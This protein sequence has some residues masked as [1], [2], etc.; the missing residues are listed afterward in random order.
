MTISHDSAVQA[1]I[2]SSIDPH[3][4]HPAKPG[5]GTLVA[6]S[7]FV[8]GLLSRLN[9]E[10][11][12]AWMLANGILQESATRAV[13]AYLRTAYLVT[14][15]IGVLSAWRVYVWTAHL[16]NHWGPTHA[17]LSRTAVPARALARPVL[18]GVEFA[19]SALLEA[20]TYS[21]GAATNALRLAV[22]MTNVMTRALGH[23]WIALANGA[24]RTAAW[25]RLA[26][27]IAA[28][29][30]AWTGRGLAP[31]LQAIAGTLANVIGRIAAAAAFVAALIAM[32]VGYL[33]GS[34]LAVLS[35]AQRGIA[36]VGRRVTVAM[37]YAVGAHCVGTCL[38]G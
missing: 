7:V 26:A 9:S 33:S 13:P 34:L 8:L 24:Q 20:L 27:R 14:I 10:D 21:I 22:V 30:L 16:L 2:D 5:L 12:L 3:I 23:V 31:V 18:S 19:R 4:H 11:I 15:I 35:T 38:L 28:G 32:V 6:V 29:G 36:N 25:A 1:P 37:A 17:V